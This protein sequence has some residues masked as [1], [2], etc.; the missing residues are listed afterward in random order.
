M[1]PIR[2]LEPELSIGRPCNALS[3]FRNKYHY[4]NLREHSPADLMWKEL[5]TTIFTFLRENI[6]HLDARG[7]L[8]HFEIFMVGKHPAKTSPTIV[9][10]SGNKLFREKAMNLIGKKILLEH[11]PGVLVAQSSKMPR[12]LAVGDNNLLANLPEGIYAEG[13]LETQMVTSISGSWV[14]LTI[15]GRIRTTCYT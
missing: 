4:W 7:S 11:Y 12:P 15:L 10:C 8:I 5:H 1:A 14:N 2:W 3:G 6:E 13:P 9:F